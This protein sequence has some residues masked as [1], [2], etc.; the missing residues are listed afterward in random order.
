[1]DAERRVAT[2]PRIEACVQCGACIVQC[3]FDALLFR[4]ESGGS[5]PAET[6]RRFKLDLIGR[7]IRPRRPEE[8]RQDK[9]RNSQVR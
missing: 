2:L 1:M 9:L 3:P 5:V 4:S 6:V 8:D 7:R